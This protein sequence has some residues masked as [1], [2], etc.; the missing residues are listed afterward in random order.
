M[1]QRWVSSYSY[2]LR[3][4]LNRSEWVYQSQTIFPETVWLL[5]PLLNFDWNGEDDAS[6]ENPLPYRRV[7]IDL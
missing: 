6:P 1:G 2:W 5:R 3:L 7:R 4:R